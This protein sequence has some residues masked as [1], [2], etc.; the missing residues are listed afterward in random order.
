MRDRDKRKIPR[1][2]K[3]LDRRVNNVS[4]HQDLACTKMAETPAALGP[5]RPKF[6]EDQDGRKL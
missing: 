4:F 1:K 3:T 6:R 5:G 2:Y